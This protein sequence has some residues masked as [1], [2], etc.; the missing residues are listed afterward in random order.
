MKF[1]TGV[2]NRNIES[3]SHHHL[4]GS[5]N[6]GEAGI[7]L[8]ADIFEFNRINRFPGFL[9][10][11]ENHSEHV[12]DN[13]LLGLGKFP[14]F[15]AGVEPAVTAKQVVHHQEYQVGIDNDQCGAT[16]WLDLH[17]IE[18]TRHRQIAHEFAVLQYSYRP[19]GDFRGAAY[20]IE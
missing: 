3:G 8:G 14:A 13:A 16:Q 19:R 18:V 12:L 1:T 10:I 17:H 11:R 9:V 20:E 4:V 7:H 15:D 6:V 5:G 2:S